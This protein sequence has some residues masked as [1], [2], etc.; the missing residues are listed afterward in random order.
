MWCLHEKSFADVNLKSVT[1]INND[2]TNASFIILRSPHN[3]YHHL[4]FVESYQK[5]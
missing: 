1:E 4:F 3:L 5:K 2:F